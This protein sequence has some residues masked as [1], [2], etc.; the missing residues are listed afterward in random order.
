MEVEGCTIGPG[1]EMEMLRQVH[2]AGKALIYHSQVL[3][4]P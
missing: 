2:L 1:R 4:A 3:V